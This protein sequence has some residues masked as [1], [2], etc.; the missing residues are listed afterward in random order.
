[1][2]DELL[3]IKSH[4]AVQR[5]QPSQMADLQR[6]NSTLKAEN[7]ILEGEVLDTRRDSRKLQ[8]AHDKALTNLRAAEESLKKKESFGEFVDL[9]SAKLKEQIAALETKLEEKEGELRDFKKYSQEVIEENDRLTKIRKDS[10]KERNEKRKQIKEIDKEKL[11]LVLQLKKSED[12]VSELT[13]SNEALKKDL[14]I[15]RRKSEELQQQ[16]H[17]QRKDEWKVRWSHDSALGP[18]GSLG[19]NKGR[20]HEVLHTCTFTCM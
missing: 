13:V 1:M 2:R 15:M 6:A 3:A 11:D 12:Q 10:E 20:S 16:H 4:G 18:D 14:K 7:A 8:A 17:H 9:Q 5:L 19:S